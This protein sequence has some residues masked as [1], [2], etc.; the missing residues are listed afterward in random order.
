METPRLGKAVAAALV[1]G[2]SAGIWA[3]QLLPDGLRWLLLLT[4]A[5]LWWRSGR[6]RWMGALLLGMAW[7]N[8]QAGWVLARQLPPAWEGREVTVTGTVVELP[9]AEARRTRFRLR[10]DSGP[11]QPA[12]L[13]GR[14]LQLAW[15]DEFNAVAP[16]P[17]TALHAGA[18]WRMTLRLRAPRGLSNP[19]GFDAERHALA[20][21]IVATGYVRAADQA[22]MLA[23]PRGIDA[24]R[25]RMARR[26]AQT[27]PA[28]SSRYVQA[29]A[30]GDTRALDDG[31]WHTLRATGLTHLIAISGFHVGLV[32]GFFALLGN[33]LWRLLPGLARRWPRPQAAAL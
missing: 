16:G 29:L 17:R 11:A 26:I 2:V 1:A 24:W 22:H 18:R 25:E 9:E 4:G 23:P 12:P 30:L 3:P 32:A 21:R 5:C 10:V 20:Q 31:D 28:S 14:L 13:R 6:W 8:L 7:V 33:G 15:Y 19:G 27:T